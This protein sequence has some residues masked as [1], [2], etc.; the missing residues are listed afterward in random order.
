MRSSRERLRDIE[1]AAADLAAF[2]DG[3]DAAA[4][5]AL[6]ETDR[7]TL[8]AVKDALAEIGEAVKHLP[9]DLRARHPAI[10][11]RGFGALRDI[12]VHQYFQVDLARLWLTLAMEL[13]GLAAAVRTELARVA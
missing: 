3:L 12:L 7:R 9:P 6:E 1:R 11:W 8:R 10:D 5:A 2:T 13:P 4:F